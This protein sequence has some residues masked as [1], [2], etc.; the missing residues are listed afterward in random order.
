MEQHLREEQNGFRKH[1]SCLD[2]INTLRIIREQSREWQA[3]LYVSFIDFEKAFDSV[4]K[5][6]L[7]LTLQQYGTPREIIHT[8]KTLYDG[9]KCKISHEGKL[10]DFIEVRNGVRQGC[11][12]S[13][14]LFLLILDRVMKRV[15]GS[16][17]SGIQ[18]RMKERL[19][20][21]DCADDICL[22]AQRF[23]D[24]EEKLKRLK[25]EAELIGLHI[26]IKK[27]KEM[28]VNISNTQK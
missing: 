23:W 1:R 4:K 17:E 2:L 27:T 20:G 5:E 14:T 9:F 7:W 3:F 15:K 19:E 18:W 11:I 22:L 12:L 10:S 28:R 13:P 26:N 21:L 16:R 25:E 24:V 8:I 6:I